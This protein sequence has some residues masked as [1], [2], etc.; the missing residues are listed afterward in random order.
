MEIAG[1]TALVLGAAMG[2]GKAIALTLAEAGARVVFTWY[3]WPEAARATM[4]EFADRGFDH[5][6][7]QVD[8]RQPGEIDRLF[9]A[10]EARYHGLDILINNIERGG[11]PVVHGAYTGE[12]WDLEMETTL[13]AKWFVMNRALP[14]LTASNDGAAIIFSSIAALVGRSGPAGLIF[15]DGYSAANR[16]VSSFTE[17]WAR[18]AAPGVRVNEL[19]L[20]FFATRHAEGTRGWSLLSEEEKQAIVDHTLLR[21][22]GTLDDII[23]AVFFLLRDAT[24]MTGVTLRLDGGYPLGAS[25]VPPLPQG[26]V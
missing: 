18:L 4:A 14:L 23:R 16:A 13:K 11:M 15:N 21:R 26:V 12:Q 3:D 20:G 25:A 17:T 9:T 24:F 2:I 5:L 6:A 10:I 1:K 19:M 22:T 8:L 7:L